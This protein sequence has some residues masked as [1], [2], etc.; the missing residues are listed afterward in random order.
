MKITKREDISKETVV[1]ET[2]QVIL[3]EWRHMNAHIY[4][5]YIIMHGDSDI[6]K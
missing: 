4:V 3:V 2:Y 5:N 1:S 6:D